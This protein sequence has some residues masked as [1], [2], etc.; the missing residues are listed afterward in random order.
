MLGGRWNQDLQRDSDAVRWL[1]LYPHKQHPSWVEYVS[2][3]VLVG[4]GNRRREFGWYLERKRRLGIDES[5][6]FQ[7]FHNHTEWIDLLTRIKGW[8]GNWRNRTARH[9]WR[10][11]NDSTDSNYKVRSTNRVWTWRNQ[12]P[13]KNE[14]SPG[15]NLHLIQQFH[16]HF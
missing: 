8:E 7:W 6:V 14:S 5:Y 13:L 15:L 1:A 11:G 10:I 2:Q 12:G 4:K 16:N 9:H 3:E